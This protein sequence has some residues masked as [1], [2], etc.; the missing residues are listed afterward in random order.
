MR[1]GDLL[2]SCAKWNG[3][4]IMFPK[5]IERCN[6]NSSSLGDSAEIYVVKVL[7]DGVEA[8][9]SILIRRQE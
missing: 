7:R 2:L 9:A 1:I 8:T 4:G 5:D 6:G 3:P